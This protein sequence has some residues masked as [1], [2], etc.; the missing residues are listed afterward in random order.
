M[1][2]EA[3]NRFKTGGVVIFP[4]DTVY[5]IGCTISKKRAVRKIYKIRRDKPTK[6]QLIL[7]SSINQAFKYGFFDE[8]AKKFAKMFWPGPLTVVVRARAKVPKSIRSQGETVGIRMPNQPPLL[9]IIRQVGEP[10]LAPS[11]NFHGK[12]A[13][14]S[15]TKIDK[16]LLALVDYAINFRRL[17]GGFEMSKEPST[18]VDL[19]KQPYQVIRPGAIAS[20]K[21]KKAVEEPRK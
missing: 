16:K 18:V 14:A 5:G 15:F 10:I 13:P 19:T 6:P 3:V 4:T 2:K 20:E 12:K 7:V 1:I 11:A 21:L 17:P 9:E 8:L